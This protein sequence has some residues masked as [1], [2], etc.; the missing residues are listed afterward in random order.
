MPDCTGLPH[1]PVRRLFCTIRQPCR[2]P[3]LLSMEEFEKIGIKEK[4][5]QKRKQQCFHVP[6]M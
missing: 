3:G 6:L 2:D 1:A 5:E 4:K